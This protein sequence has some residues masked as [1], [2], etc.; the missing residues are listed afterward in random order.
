M[1]K[2]G[3]DKRSSSWRVLDANDVASDFSILSED[4]IR[5]ITLGTYQVKMA[6]AYTHEHVQE[7]GA[8]DILI[9]EDIPN[10]IGAKIQSWH[11][12]SKKYF[13]IDSPQ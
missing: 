4:E 8:Y 9:T 12:S 10:I 3:W 7:D 13:W 6:K 11:V 2:E 5:N 1:E